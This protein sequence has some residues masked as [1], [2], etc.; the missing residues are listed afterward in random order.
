MSWTPSFNGVSK[1]R[2]IIPFQNNLMCYIFHS[3]FTLTGMQIQA[4]QL[5]LELHMM[6]VLTSTILYSLVDPTGNVG[7]TYISGHF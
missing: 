5:Q 7:P 3:T 1:I 6:V 4:E 2:S